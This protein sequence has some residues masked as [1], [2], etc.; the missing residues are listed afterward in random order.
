MMVGYSRDPVFVL[1][2]KSSSL[3]LQ[4]LKMKPS[5]MECHY[6]QSI[7]GSR[8]PLEPLEK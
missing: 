1:T 7:I 8:I 4:D 6:R 5:P 2:C 3:I